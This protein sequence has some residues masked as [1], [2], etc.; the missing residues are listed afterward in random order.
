MGNE[1]ALPWYIFIL[2]PFYPS[3]INFHFHSLVEDEV[4]TLKSKVER[5][6]SLEKM[7]LELLKMCEQF[8]TR[9]TT[10]EN[11]LKQVAIIVIIIII[12]VV[13]IIIKLY[14]A[15]EGDKCH[16][17]QGDLKETRGLRSND[18]E[19]SRNNH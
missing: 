3:S 11:Q 13:I 10:L 1:S 12:I 9:V 18:E 17:P 7:F 15:G 2:P 4:H 5:F 14:Q 16:F 6:E 8:E 19:E